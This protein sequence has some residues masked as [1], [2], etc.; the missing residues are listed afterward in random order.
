MKKLLLLIL[1]FYFNQLLFAQTSSFNIGIIKY[2]VGDKDIPNI[3]YYLSGSIE[4]IY[5]E[6]SNNFSNEEYY[7]TSYDK[8]LYKL[9][10][11]ALNVGYVFKIKK[12]SVIPV[13]G[14]I[15]SNT[16]YYKPIYDMYTC[17]NNKIY[18]NVGIIGEFKLFKNLGLHA[19]VGTVENFKVGL[20]FYFYDY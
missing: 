15:S 13:I 10:L 11:T 1:L 20:S 16:I 9:D 6:I 7:K 17:V 3:G 14:L 5:L 12:F 2:N 4:N 18:L 8:N 19:G